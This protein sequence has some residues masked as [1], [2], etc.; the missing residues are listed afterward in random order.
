MLMKKSAWMLVAVFTMS[1]FAMGVAMAEEGQSG[2]KGN[3]FNSVGSG[4]KNCPIG[5]FFTK[6]SDEYKSRKAAGK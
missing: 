3:F 1:I 4:I 6:K 5:Q 2:S